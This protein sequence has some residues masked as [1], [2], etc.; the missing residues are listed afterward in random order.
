[1]KLCVVHCP[2]FII[3]LVI[4][5]VLT[6]AC[7]ESGIAQAQESTAYE[8]SAAENASAVEAS[9]QASAE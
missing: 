4:A 1:M 7:L 3:K 2:Q 6:V 9:K 5:A 8:P